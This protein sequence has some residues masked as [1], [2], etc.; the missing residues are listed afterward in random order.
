MN[1]KLSG[2]LVSSSHTRSSKEARLD[3]DLMDNK[4]KGCQHSPKCIWC[5]L[6]ICAKELKGPRASR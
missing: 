2:D 6:P 5:P 4:D 1:L 3:A